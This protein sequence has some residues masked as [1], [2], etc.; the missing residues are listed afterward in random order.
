ML[1]LGQTDGGLAVLPFAALFEQLDTL[2]ALEDGTLAADFGVVLEAVV[3]GHR[4]G[5]LRVAATGN[6]VAGAGN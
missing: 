3:L 1:G 4:F 5:E 2:E 6:P